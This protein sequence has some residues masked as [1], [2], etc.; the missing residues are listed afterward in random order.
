[1]HAAW[2]GHPRNASG[3][4]PRVSN[5]SVNPS[6]PPGL[7]TLAISRAAAPLSKKV[8]VAHSE[9]TAS[10]EASR[11]GNASASPSANP[12]TH[13]SFSRLA[14]A[15][16][17]ETR[18]GAR[19]TPVTLH[20]NCPANNIAL[21]PLPQAISSARSDGVSLSIRPNR[22]VRASP[23]GCNESPSSHATTGFAYRSA[24]QGL[25][26]LRILSLTAPPP[27]GSAIAPGPALGSQ[28][29]CT[30]K[31][32]SSGRLVRGPPRSTSSGS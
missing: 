15:R 18:S 27:F 5:I 6:R 11:K 20:P 2:N 24:Q 12:K 3:T 32:E 8:E 10:K 29:C 4:S 7:R 31:R 28:P 1:M 16:A 21:A 26:S 13:S 9:T 25:M 19:S 23:P 30:H 17:P 14:A 22:C